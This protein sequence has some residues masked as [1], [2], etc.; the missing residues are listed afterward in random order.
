MR[1]S[2]GCFLLLLFFCAKRKVDKPH[3]VI[4]S[5]KAAVLKA[6]ELL[7][8]PATV[9]QPQRV[10]FREKFYNSRDVYRP[11]WMTAAARRT[12]RDASFVGLFSFATFLLRQKKS[13]STSR[14]D[15]VFEG[16]ELLIADTAHVLDFVD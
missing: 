8:Q 1:R 2:S 12:T 3:V 13:R 4:L 9:R 6:A 10:T 7:E 11:S 15:F 16:V 5:L 14:R